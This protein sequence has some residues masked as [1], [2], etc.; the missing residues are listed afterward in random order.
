MMIEDWEVGALFWS[1][2]DR[3]ASHDE[4]SEFV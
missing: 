1:L 3:G 2:A 4:A